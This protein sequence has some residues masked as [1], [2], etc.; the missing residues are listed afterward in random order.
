ML[1]RKDASKILVQDPTSIFQHLKVSSQ[2]EPLLLSPSSTH[3]M[4]MR[5]GFGSKGTKA[6]PDKHCHHLHVELGIKE[7]GFQKANVTS[8][9]FT[10][11]T[12]PPVL[13]KLRK[14]ASREQ[15][16]VQILRD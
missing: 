16:F 3:G 6:L 7:P 14:A 13:H 1:K 4:P 5:P 15:G 2:T 9:D 8:R 11:I 10:I 12:T